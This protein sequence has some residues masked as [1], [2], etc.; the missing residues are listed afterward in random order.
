V[1]MNRQ[2]VLDILLETKIV[3][4]VRMKERRKL[5]SAVRAL[6]AGGI[7]AVEI[8]LTTPGA[9]EAVASL[10]EERKAAEFT[11]GAGTVLDDAAA[12][13]AVRAGAEFL[14]SPI[15]DTG[16]IEVGRRAECL[17]APGAFTP[18]EIVQALRAGA[19]IVKI[20][21]AT[22]LGPQFFKDI[23]GP[24]PGIRLMPTGGVT[25][26]NAPDFIRAGA[27]CVGIGTALLDAV[28]LTAEDW[29]GLTR[30]T[31]ALV[32]SLRKA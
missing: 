20:F 4:V 22:S 28:T 10:I 30:K 29:D 27:C 32:E 25:P 19:D 23:R 15:T 7:K 6:R 8:T 3:A 31:R 9:L 1:R 12:E 26:E 21:P 17:V 18:T 11:V 16:M 2:T 13:E 24:L 5:E 14:V